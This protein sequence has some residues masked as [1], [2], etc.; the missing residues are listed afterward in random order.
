ELGTAPA[1]LPVTIAVAWTCDALTALLLITQFLAGGSGRLLALAI[2]YLWSAAVLVPYAMVFPGFFSAT[3]LLG[4]SPSSSP[5][6]WTAWHV[7]FPL[8]IALALA[9]WPKTAARAAAALARDRV[10][11][12]CAAALTVLAAAA[13]TTWLVTT[14][15]WVP[16][17]ITG[18]DY[19]ALTERFGPAI[20]AVNAVAVA[21]AVAGYLSR[22]VRGLEAWAFV[23]VCASCGD[24]A[25][26]LLARSRF[27]VGWY[28]ARVLTVVAVLVVLA[29]LMHQITLVHKRV[30]RSADELAALVESSHD[31]IVG[32]T[33]DGMI[34]SWNPG[35]E[36]L[37]GYT[38]REVIGHSFE[39]VIPPD[40]RPVEWSMLR[41]TADGERVEP[42]E[43]DRVHKD[44]TLVTV[45]TAVSPIL[46]TGGRVVGVASMSR[47]LSERKL[48]EAKFRWMLEV[49]P[50]AILGVD[51]SGSIELVNAQ[52]E[53]MFGY[54]RE[55]LVGQPVEIL[56][57]DNIRAMHV[58]HRARYD[59][60]PTPRQM[61]AGLE[62]SAL[63]K[64]GY[65][66]PVEISL[67]ALEGSGGRLTMAAVRDVTGR[68]LIERQLREQN[69][70]L[71][72]ASRAK[73]NFLAS[74]SHELRTPLNAIIGFTGTM[75]M[76][77]PGPLNTDQEHQLRLVQAS[78]KHLLSIINDL[79][80][81]AKIESGQVQIALEAVD[82]RRVVEE[83]VQS[84]QPLAADKGVRLYVD[85]PDTAV[86]VTA[87]RRALGQILINLINNAI[88]FTDAGEVRVAITP[89]QDH[90]RAWRISVSDTGPGIPEADLAR[91]FRAFE[92][93]AATAKA[94]DEG[95]GLGLHIS[96]KLAEL[97]H[98]TLTVTS[99]QGQ[100]STFTISLAE[101]TD[102]AVTEPAVLVPAR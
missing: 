56:I 93:S 23:A 53:R 70:E 22:P 9:P 59:L 83:V 10:I 14:Q 65:E 66:I 69:V 75:L 31:A 36:N 51:S 95:T 86:T 29:N 33:V 82:C 18:S 37:Y 34:T 50:D 90:R 81:L 2:A 71:E 64:D 101:G 25:L 35:A 100:G 61:G 99:A 80:D 46:D 16:A 68:R 47:D 19:S 88:K 39:V 52:C 76:R 96:R 72:R 85:A 57:P 12:G 20:L 78:G 98:A 55:E 67:S 60:A 48:A 15:D 91:I 3:G 28:G 27:T 6:L 84:L 17:I 8:L 58:G 26:T 63:H 24:T 74:M 77:L 4:A 1:F 89:S 45:S 49:A 102:S 43:A 40:A 44:G 54:Q 7:G 21:V 97:L 94:A 73:D 13:A 38:A 5:W 62:L 30:R 42:Y 11:A 79:L 41:R 92:R 32:K 87:D